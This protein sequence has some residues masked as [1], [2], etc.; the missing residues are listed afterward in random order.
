[1]QTLLEPPVKINEASAEIKDIL[2]R[3]EITVKFLKYIPITSGV[4]SPFLKV[5][6]LVQPTVDQFAAKS[7]KL[8]NTLKPVVDTLDKLDDV[9]LA[10]KFALK[11]TSSE[12]EKAAGD[13][14]VANNALNSAHIFTQ[15]P[16]ND[17]AFLALRARLEAAF[18][19]VDGAVSAINPLL[20]FENS[21]LEAINDA[22]GNIK[23][24]ADLNVFPDLFGIENQLKGITAILSFV[25]EPLSYVYD[26]AKA[27]E[28][29]LGALSFILKPFEWALQQALQATG[30]Q[31]L[32]DQIGNEINNAIASQLK[33]EIFDQIEKQLTDFLDQFALNVETDFTDKIGAEIANIEAEL[34]AVFGALRGSGGGNDL[35]SGTVG[36]DELSGGAGADILIG[37]PGNDKLDGGGIDGVDRD[38]AI[39]TGLFSEHTV[40][41]LPDGTW[42]VTDLRE[43]G[44]ENEGADTLIGIE[45]L[46]FEDKSIPIGDL[47]QVV[48]TMSQAGEWVLVTPPPQPNPLPGGVNRWLG[49]TNDTK[50]DWIFASVGYDQIFAGTGNDGIFGSWNN[51]QTQVQLLT[52][53]DELHGDEGDDFIISGNTRWDRIYGGPGKD[54]AS[55]KDIDISQGGGPASI[56]LAT[57]ADSPL[58]V[59]PSSIPIYMDFDG[60]PWPSQG[61]PHWGI[62]RGVEN[63]IGSQYGDLVWGDLGVNIINGGLGDD[64]ICGLGGDDQ[65]Y[66]EEGD[67]VL[68]GDRGSDEVVGGEGDDSFIGGLGNDKYFGGSG[69]DIAIYGAFSEDGSAIGNVLN[70]IEFKTSGYVSTGLDMPFRIEAARGATRGTTEVTK[71]DSSGVVIGLDVLDSVEDLYGTQGADIIHGED[72]TGQQ[73]SGGPG[74]DQIFAGSG[75]A[76][77]DPFNPGEY[78]AIGSTLR[79]GADNDALFG[80]PGTDDIDGE[81]GNDTIAISGSEEVS[82]PGAITS[83]V[84]RLGTA[85]DT[86][87]GGP[88]VD[89]LD[90]SNSDY[91]WHMYLMP[92][93]GRAAYGFLPLETPVTT[94]QN[95]VR[96]LTV[97]RDPF[98][99]DQTLELSDI[100]GRPVIDIK[101]KTA[102]EIASELQTAYGVGAGD[103]TVE[104]M[105]PQVA[106]ED[107]FRI[108]FKG[109][110]AGRDIGQWNEVGKVTVETQIQGSDEFYIQ[111]SFDVPLDLRK[112]DTGTVNFGGRA[113]VETFE[114]IQGSQ[115]RDIITVG[116]T[117]GLTMTAH[118]NGGD[119]VIFGGQRGER[120][121]GEAATMSWAPSTTRWQTTTGHRSSMRPS[122]HC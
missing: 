29:L 120:L 28:P 62:I 67:D 92:I 61:S 9:L 53:G 38:I 39:Y 14:G 63:I 93:S 105:P 116:N 13:I 37:G 17:V 119:D 113:S 5:I 24:L 27:L 26:K 83:G 20:N 87:I 46:V 69:V 114:I 55:F 18:T 12:I 64:K 42:S 7:A 99:F 112:P 60:R 86:Y 48:Q 6:K 10:T 98:D 59:K 35:V 111:S 95:E 96:K 97:V 107:E 121:F 1:M 36:G 40:T 21:A 91:S 22:A 122:P 19:G 11:A 101:D 15:L 72:G 94:D 4:A 51:D 8:A 30:I 104:L 23:A 52:I 115:F 32:I 88:G 45:D 80:G 77:P 78:D 74:D 66:G 65:L 79:G 58:F 85:S 110:L 73:L 47:S 106:D 103:I 76:V 109:A 75:L 84:L 102:A 118:G 108:S 50:P 90:F 31:S 57:A 43:N 3:S 44:A 70:S 117:S 16:N 54:T 68:V 34:Q 100:P 41:R 49:S 25:E 82:R 89:V 71:F 81:G 33:L 2:F 56:F